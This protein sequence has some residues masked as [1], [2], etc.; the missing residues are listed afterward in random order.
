MLSF[1]IFITLSLSYLIWPLLEQNRLYPMNAILSYLV[2]EW[3]PNVLNTWAPNV[4]NT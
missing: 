3:A 4:L 1:E 2:E